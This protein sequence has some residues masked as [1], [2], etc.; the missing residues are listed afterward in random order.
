MARVHSP[1]DTL[2][3]G[4]WHDGVLLPV[5]GQQLPIPDKGCRDD[6]YLATRSAY[7]PPLPD[8]GRCDDG[9]LAARSYSVPCGEIGWRGDRAVSCRECKWRRIGDARRSGTLGRGIRE[10]IQA[11]IAAVRRNCANIPSQGAGG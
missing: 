11:P 10:V 5:G 4:R 1:H 3:G 9:Y 2:K 7:V 8:W 6:G